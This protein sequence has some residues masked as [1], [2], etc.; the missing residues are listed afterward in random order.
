MENTISSN[1]LSARELDILCMLIKGYAN[2][3][4]ADDLHLSIRT[5]S[6]YVSSLKQKLNVERRAD[7][8]RLVRENG[9][10]C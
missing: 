8:I 1:N 2:G 3:Q 5:V 10:G 9:L 7:L 4:I 6:G